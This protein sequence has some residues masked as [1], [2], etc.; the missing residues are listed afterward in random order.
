MIYSKHVNSDLHDLIIN[1]VSCYWEQ[2]YPT[3]LNAIDI[4]RRGLE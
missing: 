4:Q 2:K 3:D 1:Q